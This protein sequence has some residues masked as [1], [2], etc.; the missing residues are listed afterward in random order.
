VSCGLGSFH[1]WRVSAEVAAN[2]VGFPWHGESMFD[3]LTCFPRVLVKT[4]V[5][6][7][8]GQQ[9]MIP[10]TSIHVYLGN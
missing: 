6:Y 3:W 2:P 7:R 4:A 9:T 5:K 1:L 8:P 10:G